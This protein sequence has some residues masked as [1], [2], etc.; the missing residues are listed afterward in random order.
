MNLKNQRQHG[1]ANLNDLM[2]QILHQIFKIML[3]VL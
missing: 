1:M 3:I 2:D